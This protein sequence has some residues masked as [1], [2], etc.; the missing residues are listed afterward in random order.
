LTIVIVI[1]R[2]PI[3]RRTYSSGSP[4][5][6]QALRPCGELVVDER[7]PQ[8]GALDRRAVLAGIVGPL[9][10]VPVLVG[11]VYVALLLWPLF[12]TSSALDRPAEAR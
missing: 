8:P 6:S 7:E 12:A 2:W 3:C 11:L 1:G 5:E 10:E 9:I 4:E